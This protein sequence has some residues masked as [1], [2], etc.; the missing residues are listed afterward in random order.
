MSF[1]SGAVT[2]SLSC[3]TLQFLGNESRFLITKSSASSRS[4]TDPI[5]RVSNY[6]KLMEIPSDPITS[7]SVPSSSS[8]NSSKN[9][10]LINSQP[11]TEAEPFKEPLLEE[12]GEP[13]A[14]AKDKGFWHK[15]SWSALAPVRKI[16]NEEY[17]EKL[18][19][20]LRGIEEKLREVEE[21]LK[22]V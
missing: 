5:A 8:S 22:E 17:Q 12:P 6:P 2:F 16:S 9:S 21:E 11:E 3:L 20:R 13:K 15:F 1:L 10:G 19:E 4:N 14:K 7:S 18:R